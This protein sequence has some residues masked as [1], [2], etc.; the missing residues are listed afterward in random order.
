MKKMNKKNNTLKEI[1]QI[2]MASKSVLLF[3]HINMDGDT[4]GS[5]VAL[6]IALRKLGKQAHILIEDDI[7]AFLQFLDR[8]YCTYDTHIIENPDICLCIDCGDVERFTKRKEKFFQGK[9][10]GCIDH[11]V[12][13]EPF[14]D[15]NY[16]D[17]KA[18]ATGEIVFDLIKE[19]QVDMDK[20]I[21]NAIF[22]AITTDTGNFQYSNTTKKT[23]LIAA[24][25]CDY[26]VDYN[27]ISVELYQ[28]NRLEKLLL[29]TKVLQGLTVF[30]AGM[31][32]ICGVTQEMFQETQGKMEET[33]GMI[34]ILRN[35]SGIEVAVFVK[36]IEENKCKV[37]MRSK[38]FVNVAELSKTLNGGGHARAAG[39]TVYQSYEETKKTMIHLVEE[40][41]KG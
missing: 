13:T 19:L 20:E 25:L 8:D 15:F 6:C 29:Q 35:I 22:A 38:K 32:A 2:L 34:E 26:G 37:S 23:H 14:A 10:K 17:P 39:C 7:A 41:L 30:A 28:N 31:A 16:I 40:Y 1:A 4:L 33:E 18:A 9:Q 24:E 5:S 36:E 11:H 3:T 21:G 27:E 12:T